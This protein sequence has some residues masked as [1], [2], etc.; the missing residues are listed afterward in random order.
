MAAVIDMRYENPLYMSSSSNWRRTRAIAEADTLLLTGPN[1]LGLECPCHRGDSNPP[2]VGF[3]L[4]T[5]GASQHRDVLF[6]MSRMGWRA[7][8]FG[9][10]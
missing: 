8:L 10:L 7:G 4:W 9:Y 3:D 2:R 1:Q 5:K 6:S